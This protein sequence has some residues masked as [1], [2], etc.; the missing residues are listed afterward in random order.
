MGPGQEFFLPAKAPLLQWIFTIIWT[1]TLKLCFPNCGKFCTE[2]LNKLYSLATL[3]YKFFNKIF[4][5][6]FPLRF[7]PLSKNNVHC[8]KVSGFVILY[9]LKIEFW[10]SIPLSKHYVVII[11]GS[12]AIWVI[13]Y[14][15][16]LLV[17]CTWWLTAYRLYIIWTELREN[18]LLWPKPWFVARC[19]YRFPCL[20]T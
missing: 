13:T 17:R 20:I 11:T 10:I 12:I 7:T 6:F 3:L 15:L 5:K 14:N 8:M 4:S 19:M 9:Y 16:L 18:A 2:L 1:S